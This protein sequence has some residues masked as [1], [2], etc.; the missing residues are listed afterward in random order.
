MEVFLQFDDRAEVKLND[1]VG[2]QIPRKGD[3][4]DYQSDRG[5]SPARYAVV[6]VINCVDY[7]LIL[8]KVQ[9]V[10]RRGT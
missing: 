2:W 6:N 1:T 3:I 5:G 7:R 9:I 8:S 10:L 4:L